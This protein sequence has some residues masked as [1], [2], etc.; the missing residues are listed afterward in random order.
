MKRIIFLILLVLT[1]LL[2]SSCNKDGEDV[3]YIYPDGEFLGHLLFSVVDQDGNCLLNPDNPNN[4]IANSSL[5]YRNTTY[6]FNEVV[7]FDFTKPKYFFGFQ[8]ISD[9]NG[10]FRYVFGNWSEAKDTEEEFFINI[11]NKASHVITVKN[12]WY[13][14]EK[15]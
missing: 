15:D 2:F 4:I 5:T 6:S 9:N 11:A 13:I 7:P 3:K 12:E 10:S 1:S 14:V 8:S